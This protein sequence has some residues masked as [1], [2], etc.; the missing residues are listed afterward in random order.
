MS[1]REKNLA[2]YES[3]PGSHLYKQRVSLE[4]IQNEFLKFGFTPNQAK[5]YILLAKS[6]PKT[7]AEV[8]KTLSFPRTET[9][10]ILHS[11]QSRGIVTGT[12]NSPA[13]Y[14]ALPLE[15]SIVAIINA[16]KEKLNM[17]SKQAEE[18]LDLWKQIPTF[19]AENTEHVSEKMQTLQGQPQIFTKVSNMIS[20]AREEILIFGSIK[21]LSRFYHSDILDTLSN[22]IIKVRI[23]MS[24]AQ[25]M[26]PF[27]KIL[28][29]KRIRLLPESSKDN[30]CFVIKDNEEILMFLRN[31]IQPPNDIF[32]MWSDSDALVD[33]MHRLFDYSWDDG[34]VSR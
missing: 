29:K 6:G 4:S 13:I 22:S 17:L 33:S 21:D 20:S 28:D 12:L 14:A 2:I 9:Y 32:A 24:P 3:E 34:V 7:A 26:P 10:F 11:L 15:Q 27:A 23:V 18:L 16:E 8:Y 31:T 1:G 19:A 30:Q 25:T 5:V